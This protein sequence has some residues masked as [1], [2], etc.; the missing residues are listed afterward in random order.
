MSH[1]YPKAGKRY[2]TEN[3]KI[4]GPLRKGFMPGQHAFSCDVLNTSWDYLG[5]HAGL[6]KGLS[7]VSEYVANPTPEFRQQTTPELRGPE[8]DLV[9]TPSQQWHPIETAPK[10]WRDVL[11]Y[12]LRGRIHIGSF[13]T[14]VNDED[15]AP[16]WLANDYDDYSCGLASTP[17]SPTHWMPLPAPP[18]SDK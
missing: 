3:G 6:N 9:A 18:M 5:R 11:L 16:L 17:I 14:D 4:T 12:D 2:V 10:D 15:G 8:Q 13:R 7:L 1:I